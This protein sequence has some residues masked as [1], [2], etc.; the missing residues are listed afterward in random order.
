[1][2]DNALKV[3][4]LTMYD[5]NRMVMEKMPDLAKKQIK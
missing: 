5:I 4:G 3:A 2:D 1:M